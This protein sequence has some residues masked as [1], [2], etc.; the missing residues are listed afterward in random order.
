MPV[1]LVIFSTRNNI[2]W[3]VPLENICNKNRI[4]ANLLGRRKTPIEAE[5][6]RDRIFSQ[7]LWES[8]ELS[9]TGWSMNS[10]QPL[11]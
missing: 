3:R 5:F 6:Y 8:L 4:L 9:L 2:G 10:V 1:V 7:I 11:V